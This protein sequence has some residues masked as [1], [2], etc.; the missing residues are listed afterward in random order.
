MNLPETV[1]EQHHRIS[2]FPLKNL[3]SETKCTFWIA[4][5]F[6]DH[7]TYFLAVLSSIYFL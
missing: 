2:L 5:V 1:L 4:Y 7:N 3:I 6:R